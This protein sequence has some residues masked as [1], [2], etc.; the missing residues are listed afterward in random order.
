[1]DNKGWIAKDAFEEPEKMRETLT[2]KF[3]PDLLKS[4]EKG[5]QEEKE[6]KTTQLCV[7]KSPMKDLECTQEFSDKK[8]DVNIDELKE[9]INKITSGQITGTKLK[10]T[11]KELET[12]TTQKLRLVYKMKG[13]QVI[14]ITATPLK[15]KMKA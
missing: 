14:L 6:G 2:I 8:L 11:L 15:K 9:L 4:I 1:M 12:I 3:D 10:D 7:L 13:K 5:L